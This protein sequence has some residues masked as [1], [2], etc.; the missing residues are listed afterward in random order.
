MKNMGPGEFEQRLK[1]QPLRQVPVEWRREILSAAKTAALANEASDT[2]HQ[3]LG[4]GAL[5]SDWR[6]VVSELFWPSPR[7]WAG[8][9]ATWL[10]LFA[11][12]HLTESTRSQSALAVER[13]GDG[14][15]QA[16][17]EE[18]RMLAEL[19]GTRDLAVSA[20]RPKSHGPRPRSEL[21]ISLPCA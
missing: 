10:A 1:E 4:W 8:M 11:I 5:I 13:A 2:V 12:N 18:A 17:R 20:D 16:R 21:R 19:L 14:A 15:L 7:I 9:A 6:S 3:R